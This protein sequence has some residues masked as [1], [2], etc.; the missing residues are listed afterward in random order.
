MPPAKKPAPIITV[1]ADGLREMM[2]TIVADAVDTQLADIK[3]ALDEV[4]SLGYETR[5]ALTGNGLG[6]N[7]GLI[8]RMSKVEGSI[9]ALQ[10][11]VHKAIADAARQVEVVAA[12]QEARWSRLKWTSVGIGIGSGVSGAGVA[13]GVVRMLGA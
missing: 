8:E 3:V 11:E 7:H 13:L 10:A 1:S 12:A 6:A 2:E 9:E 4:K 5:A